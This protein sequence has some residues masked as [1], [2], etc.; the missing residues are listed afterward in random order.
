MLTQFMIDQIRTYI[1]QS[2]A[3]AKYIANETAYT[4]QITGKAVTGAGKIEVTLNITPAQAV[5]ITEV[6]LLSGSGDILASKQEN[7]QTANTG[8]SVFYKF[9][10]NVKEEQI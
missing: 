8:E 4:A 6:R 7:I 9:I 2:I 3:T 10:F 5:T 1:V